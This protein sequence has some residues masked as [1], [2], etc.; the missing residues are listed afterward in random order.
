M[1]SN[2]RQTPPPKK[3]RRLST[4]LY[5]IIWIFSLVMFAGVLVMQMSSYNNYRDE[6]ASLE[7]N[8]ATERQ[9]HQDLQDQM[10]YNESDAY[11]EQQARDQLGL[12]RP[13]EIL[14]INEAE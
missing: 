4:W 9:N 7:A 8:L 13:D 3:K 2:P 14:F 6:L 5:V 11:I 1:P 12:I 10:V